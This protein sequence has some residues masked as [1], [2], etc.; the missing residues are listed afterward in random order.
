MSLCSVIICTLNPNLHSLQ[1]VL[2]ALQDQTLPLD[3]WQLIIVDNGSTT[4]LRSVL[5]LS[6]H[7]RAQCI[8]EEQSGL[9]VARVCGHRAVDSD[10]LVY[11]DDDN[12]LATDYLQRCVEISAAYPQLAVWSG[13]SN[14]EF[15]QPPPE[16]TRPWWP[17]L[18]I[19]NF[20]QDEV[21]QQWSLQR[22]LPH[23]AGMAVR[24]EV[25][26]LYVDHY[27]PA[28][29]RRTLGRTQLGLMSADDNDITLCALNEGWGYGRFTQ[30]Q[31]THLIPPQRLTQKYLLQLTSGMAAS[32]VVL[33]QLYP[34]F[35]YSIATRRPMLL[36]YLWHFCSWPSFHRARQL[37]LLAG[38][39]LGR[40]HLRRFA[41]DQQQAAD[42]LSSS[43]VLV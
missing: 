17:M 27:Y 6:W 2:Q 34:Q 24:R 13:Q 42:R 26:Q 11:V 8:R 9:L 12:V 18:A 19:T 41:K 25:M 32:R 1:R 40:Q 4:D 36:R 43:Q 38:E 39:A 29:L 35:S 31:L 3:Q 10:L 22:P 14:P 5:N 37:A 15:Q 7:P 28:P 20:T 16:W 33:A 21:V 30:L 23:G